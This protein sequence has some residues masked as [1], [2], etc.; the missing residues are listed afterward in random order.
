[1]AI[2]CPKCHFDNPDTLKFCG[3]ERFKKLME[4]VNYEWEHFEE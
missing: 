3:E 4:R 2:T 1:L